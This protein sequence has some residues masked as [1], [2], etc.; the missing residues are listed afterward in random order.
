MRST[1]VGD[2]YI[3]TPLYVGMKE[4][5]LRMEKCPHEIWLDTQ[6]IFESGYQMFLQKCKC[7][8]ARSRYKCLG[9]DTHQSVNN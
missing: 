9:E 3:T 4:D 5:I 6:E 2:W 7:G 1:K 8:A